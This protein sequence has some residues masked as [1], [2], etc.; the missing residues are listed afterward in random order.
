[1]EVAPARDEA[2]AAAAAPEILRCRYV[3]WA[4]GEFQYPR[5]GDSLFPGAE[6]C[7]HNSSVR[8][9][10]ELPGDDFVIIGGYESGMDAAYNLSSCKKRCSVV[11]S[12]ACWH[13]ATADP[14]TELAPYT[15]QRIRTAL[16]SPTPPRLLAP[17]R[18]F[19]VEPQDDGGYLVKARRGP[20]VKHKDGKHRVPLRESNPEGA[21]EDDAAT[22]GAEVSLRT[23]H[24]PLLCA[25]FEGSVRLGVAKELFAWGIPEEVEKKGGEE[26]EEE[27]EDGEEDE[28]EAEE[29]DEDDES[30]AA[31]FEGVVMGAEKSGDEKAAAEESGA[32]KGGDGSLGEAPLLNEFDESTNT[33]GLFLVGPGVRHANMS[34]CFVYKFRQRFGVVADA[35]ARGLGFDTTKGVEDARQQNM[36]LDDFSCC[37]GAC[38][39]AC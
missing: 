30:A 23:P 31:D 26:E 5:T 4:A 21:D 6:H 15:A 2:G 18:V 17:Y 32:E 35:I 12:T 8:S 22:D 39:E 33:P 36:F 37:E 13:V 9:W 3:V 29:E 16:A 27:E 11:S 24:R 19:A 1:V 34:F 38:G 28:E 14:S 7:L 10:A 20:P 25:G